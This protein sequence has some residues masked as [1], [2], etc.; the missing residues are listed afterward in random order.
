MMVITRQK[1]RTIT[2]TMNL[3][4]RQADAK[5]FTEGYDGN[6]IPIEITYGDTAAATLKV[7]MKRCKLKV[8][9]IEFA[10]PAV[11][12]SMPMTAMGTTGEDSLELVFM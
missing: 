3:Y 9:T 4:F 6:E 11:N 10:A 2:S 8:P 12:L 7:Y 5:Y 1:I